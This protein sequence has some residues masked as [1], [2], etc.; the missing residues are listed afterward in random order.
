MS[1]PALIEICSPDADRW[2][3]LLLE[4]VGVSA[5]DLIDG[6]VKVPTS[7]GART[8]LTIT[9]RSFP[10]DLSAELPSEAMESDDGV[11]GL[12]LQRVRQIEKT[13]PKVEGNAGILLEMLNYQELYSIERARR[14]DPKRAAPVGDSRVLAGNCSVSSR[15]RQV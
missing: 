4:E 9:K 2:E 10:V 14:R 8:I 6:C 7:S 11:Q 5:Q 12:T 13:L 15:D 1:T 3:Q